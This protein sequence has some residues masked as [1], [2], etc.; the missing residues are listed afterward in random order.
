MTPQDLKQ[1]YALPESPNHLVDLHHPAGQEV[2]I[3]TAGPN[4]FNEFGEA[5]GQQY[6]AI[7]KRADMISSPKADWNP[8]TGQWDPRLSGTFNRVANPEIYPQDEVFKPK[9]KD[10]AEDA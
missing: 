8:E 10:G 1:R 3:G 5:G 7:D 6:E 9:S 4:K 2:V